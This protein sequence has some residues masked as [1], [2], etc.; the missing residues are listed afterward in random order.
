MIVNDGT[1]DSAGSTV[2]IT[3]GKGNTAPVAD[4]GPGQTVKA[5]ATVTLNGSGSNDVD[6][7]P[8]TFSWTLTTRPAG[9]SATLTGATTVS[10]TFVADQP[11]QYIAQLIVNDGKVNSNP[12]TVTISSTNTPPV[13][14][15]GPNQVV[16]PPILVQLDGSG[17]TDVDGNTLTYRWSLTS[18]PSG[19]TAVLS[20]TTAVKPTFTCRS[21]RNLHRAADC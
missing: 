19:S 17:S 20:S 13:S 11:G 6:G 5:G 14:N 1:D 15:A 18:V 7:D 10:P 9:S 12:S 4:A 21:C 3:V 16:F 2:T 8:L